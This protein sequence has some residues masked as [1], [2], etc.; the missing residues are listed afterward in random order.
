MILRKYI[1]IL[2]ACLGSASQGVAQDLSI[3]T[4][5]SQT[6]MQDMKSLQQYIAWQIP[7]AYEFPSEFPAYWQYGLSM[8][9][10][11]GDKSKL[12]FNA[13]TTS[14]GA[15]SVYADYS[16]K[17]TQDYALKSLGIAVH[18]E[19]LLVEVK[20]TEVMAYGQ[21]GYNH[22]D[23]SYDEYL[24]VGDQ[25]L[26]TAEEFQS[27]NIMAEV[28]GVAKYF[29]YKKLFLE[30]RIGFHFNQN[31]PLE[32]EEGDKITLPNFNDVD[33]EWTGLRLGIGIGLRF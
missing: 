22:T 28:G 4:G 16:G 18:Y 26:T 25:V 17:S 3:Y 21:I 11:V 12:G 1:I 13:Y 33:A 14:T 27:N 29:F 23:F 10:K 2:I 6:S 8:R 5:L 7:V 32:N 9:W 31:S 19:Y 30:G 24:Q 20:N 15:R